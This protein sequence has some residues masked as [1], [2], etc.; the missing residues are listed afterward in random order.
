QRPDV[1][2]LYR[3][4]DEESHVLKK[5]PSCLVQQVLNARNWEGTPLA[6]RMQS[7]EQ[8]C[9]R[10]WFRRINR[11]TP[12]TTP[13]LLRV[14]EGH[15]GGAESVAFSPDGAALASGGRDGTVRLWDARTGAPLRVL[16]GHRGG[17]ESVAFSP[18]GAALASGG[19]DGTV[20]L[21]DART[22]QPL[23]AL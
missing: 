5:H 4:L 18:D 16:E 13:A 20:R 12:P 10:T 21:W 9:P 22:G 1:A 15:C 8:L 17:V 19:H 11:P 14:L 7:A 6:A 3:V 2:A 23:R